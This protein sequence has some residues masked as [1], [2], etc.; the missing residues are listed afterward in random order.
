MILATARTMLEQS[1]PA[2]ISLRELSQHVGL[3]KSNVVRYFP[4]REAVF[5]AVLAGDFRSWLDAVEQRLPRAD[6]RR[7]A[8]TRH[9]LVAA[10]V[11]Q[12]LTEH[13]RFCDL[14][15]ASQTILERN[16]PIETAREF[17]TSAMTQVSRLATLVRSRIPEL[18]EA[19][20]FGFAGLIWALIAGV[21]PMANPSPVVAAVLAEPGF[22]TMCVDFVPAMTRALTIALDGVTGGNR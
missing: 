21:W 5:L 15:V 14:L 1:P 18:D 22:A 16:I 11:A 9:E 6:A 20:A 10:T 17:K 7:R 8:H 3:S 13:H 19:E 12:T 2:D 4:T